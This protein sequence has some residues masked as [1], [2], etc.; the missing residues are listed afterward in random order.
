MGWEEAAALLARRSSFLAVAEGFAVVD[1][2][3]AFTSEPALR[4]TAFAVRERFNQFQ[5]TGEVVYA[6]RQG[7]DGS[8]RAATVG[9]GGTQR[10]SKA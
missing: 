4:L 9:R 5:P 7:G 1:Q 6:E 3:R 2:S 10:S 8:P